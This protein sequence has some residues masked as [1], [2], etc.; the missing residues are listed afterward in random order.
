[1]SGLVFLLD[2]DN[3]LLDN[4]RITSDLRLYL[5]RE[6]GVQL[7][8]RLPRGARVTP[9]GEDFLRN[10]RHALESAARAVACARRADS[11]TGLKF[12]HGDLY[13]YT[14][15]VLKLLAA[16]RRACPG[17]PVRV[18]RVKDVEQH[19]ALRERRIDVAAMFVGTWPVPEFEALQLVGILGRRHG[20]FEDLFLGSDKLPHNV[21]FRIITQ[22]LQILL[23]SLNSLAL[24]QQLLGAFYAPGHLGSVCT[25]GDFGHE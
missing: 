4:D 5:E 14:P 2:V 10:A 3:T 8:E 1:M 24:L 22:H 20:L 23:Q 17:T 13:V 6:V 19:A 15:A 11:E 18:V 7:F 12:A 25:S 21:V 9:A 16:F